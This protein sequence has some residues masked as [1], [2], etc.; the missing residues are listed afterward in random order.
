MEAKLRNSGIDIIGDAPWGTHF[1]QFYK[2][3]EDLIDILVP[4][5]KTGLEN[6]EFCMWI[7]SE[8]LSAEEAKNALEKAVPDIDDYLKQGQ[9]EIIPYTEWYVIEGNFNSDKVLDG[10]VSKL[11]QALIDGYDGLRLSGNTFWLEKEGWNDF[12]DYEEAVDNIIGKYQMMALCTYC[13]DKCTAAEIID[14][15]NNHEF[16]LI[17]REGIWEVVESSEHKRTEEALLWNQQRNELLIDVTSRLLTSENPQTIID[18]LCQK[19]MEFLEC[20]VFFNYLVDEK[21]G[22]LHLNAYG[23]I[24]EEEAQKIEWLDYGA[25][26][27]GYVALESRRII[28]ENIFE[29]PDPRTDL[30][31]SYGVQ[32]YACHP[33]MI[34]GRTIGTLSFGTNSRIT[35]TDKEV[36]VMKTVADQISIAMNRLLSNRALKEAR[37]NLEEQVEERTAELEE[38][39]ESLKLAYAYNRSLIEASL[40]PL[41]TIGPDGKITDVNDSTEAITGFNRNILIGTDFSNYFTEPEKAREGYQEVFREGFV[42][43]Y[44]LE[45]L[46]KKGHKTS[47]LYNASVYKDEYGK[48]IG[49]FAAARDI[50][51]RKKAEE[52]IQRLA[53]IVE[54]SDDAIIGKSLE[55][56]IISWNKGAEQM[57]GYKFEEVKGKN[58]SILAP[59]LLKDEMNQLIERIKHGEKV[60]HY[61]TVRLRKD[62]KEI[63]LSLTLSPIFDTSRNLIGV[64]TIARDIT[65]RKKREEALRLS[66]SYNRSLIEAS[67]DPLVT[68]G[69][70]GK[71]TDVNGATE[72]VT[73]YSR[74][75]LIG[76]YFSDYFTESMKARE[77]Y[78]QVFREGEVRDYEL[79]IRHKNGHL[80]PVLYNAS[81]YRDEFGEVIGIFAAA[82][83]ITGIKQAEDKL[84]VIINELKRSNEEL[85]SFAFITSHDLQE[86]LRTMG[87]YAGLLKHRY[88]GKLDSDANDFIEYMVSGALRMQDMIKGLLDYSRVET[89]GGEFREFSA[90]EALDNALSNLNSQLKNVMLK[91]LMI[92]CRLFLQMKTR[93]RECSRI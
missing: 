19:I 35:F 37:D 38:A 21:K 62:K 17:K 56:T 70:D 25:V 87:S 46:H 91:L 3:K 33:L 60:F 31:K 41:V 12:V 85:R 52:E 89:H 57:Y 30:V 8:P 23:G 50:T 53:N 43:D 68:I 86:P 47:V 83:D 20:D 58:V 78:K 65:E 39:Y 2:T 93:L 40:D 79:E 6:N 72:L 42:R 88:E 24:P 63:D 16:A 9:I 69:P 1:C 51:E 59:P 10:W 61:E 45:I 18:D 80:T 29:T 92:H 34:E 71:I 5:F 28:A 54:S 36:K 26:V 55:G 22:C 76:T 81:A 13:L 77:G 15:V 82:R 44:P 32:A 27:C 84:K 90:E 49:V 67:L 75:E 64:S 73:G 14:V 74:D 4:Y 66:N 7:T 48:V 11:N